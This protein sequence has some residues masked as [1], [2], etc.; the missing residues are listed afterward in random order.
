MYTRWRILPPLSLFC[1]TDQTEIPLKAHQPLSQAVMQRALLALILFFG[2]CTLAV[3]GDFEDGMDAYERQDYAAAFPK[4][5]KA[6]EVGHAAAQYW[7]GVSYFNGRGVPRNELQ[8]Q[9]WRKKAAEAGHAAAQYW[10]GLSYEWETNGLPQDEQQAVRWYTKAAE[11]GEVNAQFELGNRHVKGRGVPLDTAQAAIWYRK[12]ANQ[13]HAS[14]QYQLGGMYAEGRGVPLDAAQAAIWYRKAAD[15]GNIS[16][17]FSL[18]SMY[19]NGT[20]VPQ[21]AAQ[22]LDWLRKAADQGNAEIQ[23]LLGVMVHLDATQAAIWYRKAADQGHASA[24]HDLGQMYRD[25]NGVPQDA[26]Q[27]VNW[28]HKAA[29]Q[30]NAW[31]QRDLGQMYRDGNGVPQDA[32][33]AVNWFRKAADQGHA[34]A[35][36]DLGDMYANGTGVPQDAAQALAWYRKL[37]D[38]GDADAQFQL[39]ERYANG[40]GVS[41][42]DQQAV[43]WY[44]KAAEAGDEMAQGAL[45]RKYAEGRGVPQDYVQAHKWLNLA[46][47]ENKFIAIERDDVARK[48]TRAQLA[49]AQRLAREWKPTT[50]KVPDRQQ[51]PGESELSASGTGFVVSRQAHVLTNY[52]VIEGC[53]T[54][55]ATIDGHQM[56]LTVVGTDGENDLAVLKLPASVSSVA[57]FREGRT[58]RAG[59]GVVVVGFPLHGLLASEA[60]VTTGTVSALAGLGNNSRFLQITAPVQPG[61]SGGPLLDQ[62]GHIVGVI[63][64]KLNAMKIAKAT[65]DIPQNVNFAINAAIAKAFLDSHGVEYETAASTTTKGSADIG[66]EAKQFTLLLECYR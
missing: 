28:F 50:S 26:A 65:G 29:D 3:A 16:A 11:A 30:G 44:R 1:E 12:A 57:R 4:F 25:G 24:Q 63:V 10:L 51:Q 52:H 47:V 42:N 54:I 18:F 17:Q 62:G 56:Q 22:A 58:I 36:N 13:G 55:R 49:E 37:A 15:Q 66:A 41:R 64:S 40:T 27:A 14:A 35:Q 9:R 43:H 5:M 61:N 8:G 19:S 23:F 21:D 2:T 34:G 60:N 20:G 38:Q 33:Q 6:A 45:G 32:A 53:R 31:A 48:M 39:G 46:A 7:L 59:D